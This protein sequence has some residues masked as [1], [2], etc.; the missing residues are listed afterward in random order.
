[1]DNKNLI[2]EL[3]EHFNDLDF[4]AFTDD[5]FEL[6]WIHHGLAMVLIEEDNF[7]LSFEVN[8]EPTVAAIIAQELIYFAA[9]CDMSVDIYETFADVANE[10]GEI[11]SVLFGE[12]AIEY[13]QT[14][15]LPIKEQVN[16][17]TEKSSEENKVDVQKQIDIILDQINTKGMKSLSKGQKQFLVNFSKGK[18]EHKH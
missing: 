1:M 5:E 12:E 3:Y 16:N 10:K 13:H 18:N 2:K 15:E 9:D 11:Y 17:E 6:L 8:C 4:C 7:N 14:G